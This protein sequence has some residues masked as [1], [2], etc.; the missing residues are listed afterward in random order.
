M[1]GKVIDAYLSA[2]DRRAKAGHDVSNIHSV[3][4]FFVSRVDVLIDGLLDEKIAA[5]DDEQT[6]A[7]LR[8]LKGRAGVANAKLAYQLFKD[9]FEQEIFT[10][11]KDDGAHLQRA[12]WASTSTKNPDY[13]DVMYVDNLIGPH[14]V[15]TAPPKTIEAFRDHGKLARTIEENLDVAQQL[16]EDLEAVGIRMT[17]VTDQLLD[18]GVEKFD[19]PYRSLLSAIEEKAG[20]LQ[21]A[22]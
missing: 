3:A 6:K 21:A 8:A 18:E 20:H 7:Q 19:K 15:N 10:S 16:M 11:L 2:L 22:M 4:S 14:T 1:Y 12:L 13:S 5:S 9:K 17:D